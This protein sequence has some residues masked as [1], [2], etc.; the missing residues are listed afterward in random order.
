MSLQHISP[1]ISSNVTTVRNQIAEAARA[2]GRDPASV[3]L[4]AVSKTKPAELIRA[5]F[6]AGARD[7]GENYLQ[8]ALPKIQQ[9]GDLPIVWHYIGAVQSNK[10]RAIA[11]HFHWVHTVG[12]EK[13]ARRLSEQC[14]AGRTLQVCL[15]VNIDDDPAKSGVS[16][17]DAAGLLEAARALPNLRVRGL[18]TI[19]QRGSEPRASYARLRSLYERLARPEPGIWDTLSMGMSGDF[20]EAIAAGATHVRIGTALFGARVGAA[21]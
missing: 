9:L 20:R 6:A 4:I 17:E 3:H 19:L 16:P 10:T 5:A 18:M 13:I 21:N 7:F 14:P 11:E 2:C 15:Q 1:D 8:E 12:R